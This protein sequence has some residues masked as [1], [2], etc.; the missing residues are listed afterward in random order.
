MISQ[1]E[2]SRV[3]GYKKPHSLLVKAKNFKIGGGRAYGGAYHSSKFLWILCL[4]EEVGERDIFR[5][6]ESKVGSVSFPSFMY[7]DNL[8]VI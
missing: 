3:E 1:P 8:A 7:V 2:T 5:E 4:M 6:Y